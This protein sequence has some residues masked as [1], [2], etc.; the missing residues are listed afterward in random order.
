QGSSQITPCLLSSQLSSP[1]RIPLVLGPVP[2]TRE[3]SIWKNPSRSRMFLCSSGALPNREENIDAAWITHFPSSCASRAT[4]QYRASLCVD[5][6]YATCTS[7][8]HVH[9]A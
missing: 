7:A 2:N 4:D 9:D 5:Y 1:G 8:D 3:Q 6:S